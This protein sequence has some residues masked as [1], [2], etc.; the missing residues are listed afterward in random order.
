MFRYMYRPKGS[1]SVFFAL[2]LLLVSSLVFTLLEGARIEGL[3]SCAKQNGEL[4]NESVLAG[5]VRPLWEKYHLFLLDGA[6]KNGSLDA[7]KIEEAALALAEEN[8]KKDAEG[9]SN[10]RM[11]GLEAESACMEE[12]ALVTD[13]GGMDFYYLAADYMKDNIAMEAAEILHKKLKE[14]GGVT[15]A[16]GDMDKK[17]EDAKRGIEDAKEAAQQ[18][19]KREKKKSVKKSNEQEKT[20]VQEASATKNPLDYIGKWKNTGILALVGADVRQISD[21][22]ID[23][24]TVLEKRSKNK[25]NMKTDQK[26]GW[27]EDVLFQEY[28]MKYFTSYQSPPESQDEHA[29]DYEIE[30]MIAG[31]ASD[32]ANLVSVCE[33]IL[34]IREAANYVYLQTDAEKCSQALS[35]ATMLA[36]FS[37][38]PLLVKGV[39]QAILAVWAFAESVSDVKSLLAGEKIPIIKT[40]AD[41]SVDVGGLKENQQ[42]AK[43]KTCESG[44]SYEDYLRILLFFTKD[45]KVCLRAMNLMEQNIGR[46]EGYE[47]LR[48]D[49]LI[50]SFSMMY[51]YRANVLFLSLAT[52]GTG[53]ELNYRWSF[54]KEA[55]YFT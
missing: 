40:A 54:Y 10:Y 51:V 26:G 23:A 42:F 5:Y 13:D 29:L 30:Y 43:A 47:G 49:C 55:S 38:N 33:R 20:S 14:A 6:G 46:E 27:Y 16:A 34:V 1:S 2:I 25:G 18:E 11:F 7:V 12:Y 28:L 35:L 24:D 4:V 44:L 52:V 22:A 41:W 17:V 9:G 36:G 21:K 48:M 53:K 39:Q 37:G 19:V 32:Q 3:K 50:H 15:E 45:K 8:L 31:K